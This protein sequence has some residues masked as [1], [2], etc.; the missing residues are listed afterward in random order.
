MSQRDLSRR[1]F[2]GRS[3]AGLAVQHVK[4]GPGEP[5]WAEMAGGAVRVHLGQDAG[6]AAS[7]AWP[8]AGLVF[9]AAEP[10][11]W[12]PTA[13]RSVSRLKIAAVPGSSCVGL[14]SSLLHGPQRRRISC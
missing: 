2:F 8:D 4:A 5:T 3:A 11:M 7:A 1:Q 6:D 14:R 9:T 13:T 10:G 12:Q